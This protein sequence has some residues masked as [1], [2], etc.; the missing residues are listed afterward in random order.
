MFL[1]MNF[2]D[3]KLSFSFPEI[4]RPD[5]ES[6]AQATKKRQISFTSFLYRVYTVRSQLI[7]SSVYSR[8]VSQSRYPYC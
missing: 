5:A 2:T 3:V 1:N 7:S 8:N 4:G 6:P